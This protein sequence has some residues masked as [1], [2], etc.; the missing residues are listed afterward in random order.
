MV[1]PA[2]LN[3]LLQVRPLGDQRFG[4]A[5]PDGWQQ[6]RGAFGGLLMGALVEALQA[7]VGDPQRRLRALT[8]EFTGPVGVGDATIECRVLRQGSA[9]WCVSAA[10]SQGG[11]VLTH[12][13]GTFALARAAATSGDGLWLAPPTSASPAAWERAEVVDIAAPVAPVFTQHYEYRPTGVIPYSGAPEGTSEG[14]IRPRHT[15]GWT[16]SSVACTAD[17]WWPAMA[18]RLDGPR[19][20]ATIAFTFDL[21]AD[22]AG[23]PAAPLLHRGREYA[24]ADGYSVELRELWSADGRLVSLNH[25][26]VAIIK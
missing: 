19:P 17:A 3:D 25:Q 14:W 13:V 11:D 22:P 1:R 26:T 4:F 15:S 8:G 2:V 20:I 10:L 7:V 6:G 9:V 21:L 18:A 16:V 23:L 5:V 12:A 24:C